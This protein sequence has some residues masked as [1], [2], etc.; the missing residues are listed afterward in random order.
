[1]S[2]TNNS[3]PNSPITGSNWGNKTTTTA[4]T[5]LNYLPGS[6]SFNALSVNEL[7]KVINHL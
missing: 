6:S 2:S 7:N 1:M 4:T 3:T 5:V